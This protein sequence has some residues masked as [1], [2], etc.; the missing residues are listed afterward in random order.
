M[1]RISEQYPDYHAEIEE[2]QAHG[3]TEELLQ[4]II[5]AHAGNQMRT[6][7]LYGRYQ[8][9]EGDVPI[10]SR[11][12]RFE[13][14]EEDH[15]I[16]NR[17][18]NDFFSEIVD[19]KVGYYA[20]KP[21]IYKYGDDSASEEE[22]GGK[23]AM[24]QASKILKDFVKRNNLYDIDME[25]T[26][27]ASI[28]GYAGRL[29]YIDEA[30]NERTMVVPPYETIILYQD[31]MTSPVYAV[32]YYECQDLSDRKI[33][34]VEFYDDFSVW[35][36]EGNEGNLTYQGELRHL[37]SKCPL[38]GIPNNRELL[39]DA[40][41]VLALI[42]DYDRS[43]SDNSNDLESFANAYMVFKNAKLNEK[44][45]DAIMNKSGIIAIEADDPSALYDV[46]YLTK[47]I[48]GTFVNSHLDRAEDNIYRFSKS[49]NL[50]DPEFNAISGIALKIKM[51]GL[52][53]KCGMFQAKHQSADQY[54][55]ELLTG[56]FKKKGIP[57]DPMQCTVTR[58][59]NFPVDF[60]GDAQAVQSLTAAGLPKQVAFKALSFIDDIDYVMQLIED[61][62]DGI[63]PL[64]SDKEQ[65]DEADDVGGAAG[66]GS[67]D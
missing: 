47:S 18:N 60:Q 20:G 4:K 30:G 19:V 32:R 29:F 35:F 16:N 23:E 58:R 50:N 42:D 26:K 13:D 28:C 67:E 25:I 66:T 31:E 54:M 49:P 12:M 41:K 56:S 34:K 62:K 24:K 1:V 55:F 57:F 43:F 6:K 33:L 45:T 21:A 39:G 15:P 65:E 64:E 17:V 36:Y 5:R 27:F 3:I 38:Q 63:P 53:T 40:E 11:E 59:R 9:L 14:E 44:A 46:S 2:I 7:R 51:T 48:D 61:E 10:F 52:E 8:T 37:F 22:T